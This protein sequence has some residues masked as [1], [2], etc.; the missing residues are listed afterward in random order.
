M[1]SIKFPMLDQKAVSVAMATAAAVVAR[2]AACSE[3]GRL[4][5]GLPS[6]IVAAL[7]GGQAVISCGACGG[8]S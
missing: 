5:Q 1:L 8:P 7:L 4:V 6:L 2:Q 3:S